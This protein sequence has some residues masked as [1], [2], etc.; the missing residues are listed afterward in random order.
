MRSGGV[1]ALAAGAAIAVG[2]SPAEASTRSAALAPAT[3]G[4]GT[5][6]DGYVND[7][8]GQVFNVT[9]PAYGATGDTVYAAGGGAASAGSTT[10]TQSATSGEDSTTASIAFGP[11]DVGKVITVQG[12]GASGAT[13]TTTIAAVSSATQVTLA[14][15]ASTTVA[16]AAFTYGSDD[17]AALL[18]AIAAAGPTGTLFLPAGGY[19]ILAA[20][21]GGKQVTYAGA[22]GIRGAGGNGQVN[23]PVGNT[24]IICADAAAGLQL[25]GSARYEGFWVEGAKLATAPLQCGSVLNGQAQSPNASN[26]VFRDVRVHGS[27][28][29]GWAIYGTQNASFYDCDTNNN[30]LDGL[31]IDGG[32]SGLAFYHIEEAANARYAIH[33]DGL[34]NATDGTVQPTSGIAFYS[35]ILDNAG[36]TGINKVRLLHAVNWR[37]IGLDIYGGNMTGPVVWL[38]QSSCYG[39]DFSHSWIWGSSAG[40]AGEAFIYLANT[41]PSGVRR[42]F[43]KTDG[44]FFTNGTTGAPSLYFEAANG[45]YQYSAIGWL[46]DLAPAA[47]AGLPGPDTLLI[48][49]TG[50]WQA[51]AAGGGWSGTVNY[52]VMAEGWIELKGSLAYSGSGN[53]TILTLP[54]GYQ[55]DGAARELPAAATT[56]LAVIRID[57]SGNVTA[58]AVNGTSFGS[59][60]TLY[61]DGL[62]FPIGGT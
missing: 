1:A 48:G 38:D 35:G 16:N 20:S 4:A 11:G 60:T 54:L 24:T 28:G 59:S 34:V 13:L 25:N 58:A 36:A 47:A 57:T 10:F 19:T 18:A 49:R 31:Y 29:T 17:T 8:G 12:A 50:T 23:N 52:R 61:L 39:L 45:W 21:N 56:G 30:V 37:F 41:P 5:T 14:I 32:A 51:A 7:Q 55:P 62:S 44:C 40:P 2:R 22:G 42:T 26:S 27:A 6:F 46:A 3:S 53:G 9:N 15:A 33:G 43:V